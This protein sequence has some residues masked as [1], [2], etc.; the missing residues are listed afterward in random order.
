MSEQVTS[1]DTVETVFP[2]DVSEMARQRLQRDSRLALKS[3]SCEYLNGVLVL[4]GRVGTFYL[5]QIAQELVANLEGKERVDNQIQVVA[6][7]S[8]I[9]PGR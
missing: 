2:A 6:L 4:R 9:T 1:T 3:I 7:A 8:R 5:K